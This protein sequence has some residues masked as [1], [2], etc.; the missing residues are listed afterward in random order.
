MTTKTPTNTKTSNRRTRSGRKPKTTRSEIPA[1]RQLPSGRWQVYAWNPVLKARHVVKNPEPG[2]GGTWETEWQASQAQLAHLNAI[3][4]GYEAAGV[5]VVR[6]VSTPVAH[7]F[8]EVVDEWL[9]T[10]GGTTASRSTRKSVVK[11]LTARFGGEDVATITKQTYETWDAQEERGDRDNGVEPK[12]TATR[13]SRLTYFRQIIRYAKDKGYCADDITTGL[14][15]KVYRNVEPVI[16]SPADF[17]VLCKSM[18]DWFQAAA[19]LSYEC[20]LRA[21][22]VA[23]LRWL[24]ISDL[25]G[26]H[27]VVTVKD[28]MERDMVRRPITKGGTV[29]V[30]PLTPNA[31]LALKALRKLHGN[32]VPGDYVIRNSRNNPLAPNNP[33]RIL[34]V[35]F[36]KSGLCGEQPRYHD[37]RHAAATRMKKSGADLKQIQRMLGHADLKI[38]D[39]YLPDVE[40]EDL[41]AAMV[42]AAQGP[43][44]E[45]VAEPQG[46]FVPVERLALI[47]RLLEA[48]GEAGLLAA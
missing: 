33:A 6:K 28:V 16:L 9:P 22:E 11:G 7:P 40:V 43:V 19:V 10:Q 26:D 3:D 13:Q 14:S 46:V 17:D 20:G 30:V 41:R 38:T 44:A 32:D 8:A 15:V 34:R 42:R 2:S 5:D 4:S 48:A 39:R 21:A 24:R 45:A 36:K 18:P 47:E 37:L 1:P 23:G 25:D 27:P 29:R 31:V 12:S 35:A